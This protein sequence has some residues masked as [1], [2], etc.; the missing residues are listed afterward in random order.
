MRWV[1]SILVVGIAYCFGWL[2]G[3]LNGYK[4]RMAEEVLVAQKPLH[5]GFTPSQPW[6]DAPPPAWRDDR[7]EPRD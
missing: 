7:S 4:K 6:P 5:K 2:F 1:F 3:N